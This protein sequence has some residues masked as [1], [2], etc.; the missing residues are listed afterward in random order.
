MA[1]RCPDCRTRR[2]SFTLLIAHQ[3]KSGHKLCKCGGYHYAHRPNSPYCEK[4]AWSPLRHA[5]REG[6]TAE[7]QLDIIA[8]IAWDTPGKV[9]V[10][11]PF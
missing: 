11:C 4:N 1:F 5:R 6:A 8:N 2:V 7:T 10:T 9:G 3:R